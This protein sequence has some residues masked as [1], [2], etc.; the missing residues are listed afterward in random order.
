[1]QTHACSTHIQ[2]YRLLGPLDPH[3]AG[4][5]LAGSSSDGAVKGSVGAAAE[6]VDGVIL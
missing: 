6:A 3:G 4:V 2:A 1:M 5:V